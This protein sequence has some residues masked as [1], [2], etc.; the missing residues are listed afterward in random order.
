MPAYH[1]IK[2]G[3]ETLHKDRQGE[4]VKLGG[5]GSRPLDCRAIANLPSQEKASV[6]MTHL[7]EES[8]RQ[9]VH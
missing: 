1:S 7:K 2:I 4:V 8:R 6:T 9:K 5:R 3:N